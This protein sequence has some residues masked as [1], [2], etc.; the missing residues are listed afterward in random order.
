MRARKRLWW[1][2]VILDTHGAVLAHSFEGGFPLDLLGANPVVLSEG[3]SL[4]V[5]DTEEGLMRDIAVPIFG[6]HAG[7]V[8]VGMSERRLQHTVGATTRRLLMATA[9]VS[10][11]GV[12]A[13]YLLTRVLTHPILELVQVTQAVA[14]GD[15]S[16]KASVWAH[17]E[18]GQLGTAFNAMTDDLERARQESEEFNRQLLRRNLELAALNAVAMAVS[19]PLDLSQT[20]ERALRAV[21]EATGFQTGWVFLFHEDGQRRPPVCWIGLPDE[22]AQW[23]GSRESS[24]CLCHQAVECREPTVIRLEAERCPAMGVELGQGRHITCHATVPLV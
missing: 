19:G 9:L 3:F 14:R 22:M 17:D 10:L 24:P 21:L 1:G 13:A 11:L 5:L 8:H 18:I 7:M 16:R 6:G 20:M 15:L 4:K 2:L 23:E 12:A